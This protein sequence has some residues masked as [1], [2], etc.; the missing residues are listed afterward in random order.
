MEGCGSSTEAARNLKEP[1]I[2][3]W[4]IYAPLIIPGDDLTQ[5]FDL[6][7][8]RAWPRRHFRSIATPGG[9]CG[10]LLPYCPFYLP[11]SYRLHLWFTIYIHTH[12]YSF[13][14]FGLF[15]RFCFSQQQQKKLEKFSSFSMHTFHARY[16]SC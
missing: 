11:L 10:E 12:M 13:P 6:M 4:L 1:P 3:C 16:L 8:G 2:G 9:C 15:N 7:R 14:Y 5:E